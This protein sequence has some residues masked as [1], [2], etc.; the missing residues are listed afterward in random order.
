MVDKQ[1]GCFTDA[2]EFVSGAGLAMLGLWLTGALI[3]S[4]IFEMLLAWR[5]R[6]E[7]RHVEEEAKAAGLR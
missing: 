7:L 6:W 1:L 5:R 2:G 4:G 3:W